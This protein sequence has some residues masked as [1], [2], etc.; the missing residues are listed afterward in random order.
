MIREA[1]EIRNLP[2]VFQFNGGGKVTSRED[3]EKRRIEIKQ[4]LCR[5]EYGGFPEKHIPIEVETVS[6]DQ[7]YCGGTA[8][9]KNIRCTLNFGEKTFPLPI[10]LALPKREAACPAFLYLDFNREFPNK[11]LPVEEICDQGFAVASLYYQSVTSDDGDLSNGL[12]G[13][14]NQEGRKQYGKLALWSWAAMHVMDYLQTVAE[15][16]KSHIAIAGHS[17]LGKTALLTGAFDERF[18]YT[19][20]NNSGQGGAAISRGKKG[21]KIEDIFR[22]FP[23]WFSDSYGKYSGK[24]ETL[25]FDQHYLLSLIAPRNLYVSSADG[26]AW[27]DPESE[28]LSCAAASPAYRFYHLTGLDAPG[29]FPAPGTSFHN[30]SIGYHLRKGTHY[31]SRY[32]WNQFMA[33]IRKCMQK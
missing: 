20:S 1:L 33:Y 25:P 23:Y 26:D 4:L 3:W 16:D 15:I 12:S 24:E 18:Q 11:Y 13:L 6:E 32:D 19:V 14:Y 7:N 21:E 28:F 17:R 30:G 31:L 27:A 8:V 5:E 29:A 10:T 2:D 22:R 9:L